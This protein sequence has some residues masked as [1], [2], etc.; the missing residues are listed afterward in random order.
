[1]RLRRPGGDTEREDGR[2]TGEGKWRDV[3][4]SEKR[5]RQERRDFRRV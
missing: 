5:F 4:E 2:E 1:V 3:K